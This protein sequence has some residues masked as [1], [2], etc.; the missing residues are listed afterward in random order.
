[1]P[2]F[3][4]HQKIILFV[5]R[6]SGSLH[7]FPLPDATGANTHPLGPSI[8][9][10]ANRLEIRQPATSGFVVGVADIITANGPFSA[11]FTNFC[12]DFLKLEENY[13]I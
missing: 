9:L 4:G 5:R 3:L 13:Q 11:Y 2:E 1:M 8:H 12:H 7:N 10:S 6:A